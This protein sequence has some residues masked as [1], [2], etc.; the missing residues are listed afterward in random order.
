MIAPPYR[1]IGIWAQIVALGCAFGA[2]ADALSAPNE[3][4]KT[5]ADKLFVAS[6][7]RSSAACAGGYIQPQRAFNLASDDKLRVFS[8]E[9]TGA[10]DKRM[11]L[12]GAVEIQQRDFFISAPAVDI[13][14]ASTI[15]F[16]QGLRLEQPHMV[17]RG[18]QAQWQT[19]QQQL[20]IKTA[21]LV[22]AESGLRAQ[23]QRLRRNAAGLLPIDA[24]DFS[25]CPPG[26]DGWSL[27][28][29]AEYVMAENSG[30]IGETAV[31]P[32]AEIVALI[33]NRSGATV[34][35]S[36]EGTK[37]SPLYKN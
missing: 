26:A 36:M 29:D 3:Q 31:K 8:D 20:Q 28:A 6:V 1:P 30:W 16:N 34:G 7:D 17:M 35:G 32:A 23:A 19:D 13:N 25:F 37:Y 33:F 12:S 14:A 22:I 21:E 4:A 24:G 10:L 9:L 2:S 11:V 18:R 5:L 15:S 27:G